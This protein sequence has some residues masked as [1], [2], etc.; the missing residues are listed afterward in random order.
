M[1]GCIVQNGML[2]LVVE[3]TTDSHP[4]MGSLP[5]PSSSC[6]LPQMGL[7]VA[8]AVVLAVPSARVGARQ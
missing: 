3:A 8:G 7:P 4:V 1:S 2:D 5:P 6:L